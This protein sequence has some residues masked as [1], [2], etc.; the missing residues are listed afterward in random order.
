VKS[1]HNPPASPF[2]K[3]ER[4]CSPQN[5]KSLFACSQT[6][7]LFL[8]FSVRFFSQDARIRALEKRHFAR[9]RNKEEQER[10]RDDAS[11][12]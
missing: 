3:G 7:S 12:R 2:T 11:R 4:R 5:V 10:E 9:S 6:A 1:L 8:D